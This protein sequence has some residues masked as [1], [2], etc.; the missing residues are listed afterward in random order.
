MNR[1]V[2]RLNA[3][4]WQR[5]YWQDHEP[6]PFEAGV[7]ES[8][9]PDGDSLTD[10]AKAASLAAQESRDDPTLEDFPPGVRWMVRTYGD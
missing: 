1:T 3:P 7:Q 10:D 8:G 2:G 4:T 5:N 6:N 9:S